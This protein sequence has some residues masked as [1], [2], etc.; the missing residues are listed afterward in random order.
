VSVVTSM[1]AA[2]ALSIIATSSAP[3]PR[4]G[5]KFITAWVRCSAHPER[6]AISTI[7]PYASSAPSPYERWCGP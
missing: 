3:R 1:P 4:F 5:A 2:S 7:S 6:R